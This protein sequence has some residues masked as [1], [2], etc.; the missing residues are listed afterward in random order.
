MKFGCL[1]AAL[2]FVV[3][4]LSFAL[5][6]AAPPAQYGNLTGTV[7]TQ[8]PAVSPS[9]PIQ[10]VRVRALKGGHV[11][12]TTVT[13]SQGGYSFTH[14]QTGNY[15]LRFRLASYFPVSINTQVQANTTRTEDAF[16]TPKLSM[17]YLNAGVTSTRNWR[18][19]NNHTFSVAYTWSI[20][21]SSMSGSGVATPGDSTFTTPD[22]SKSQKLQL[23]VNG[24]LTAQRKGFKPT[25][26]PANGFLAG[27]VTDS[28]ALPLAGVTVSVTNSTT[29]ALVADDL[30]ASDGSYS[31]E[32]SPGTYDVSFSLTGYSSFTAP[33]ITV[34]ANMTAAQNA[35]LNALPTS[36]TVTGTVTDFSGGSGLEGAFVEVLNAANNTIGSDTTD[37]DGT[38]SIDV[39]PGPC[40]VR[41]T[42]SGYSTLVTPGVS[43][44]AGNTTIVD[45]AL[46]AVPAP[47]TGHLMGFVTDDATSLPIGGATVQV[48]DSNN[49]QVGSATTDN[50]QGGFDFQ[51]NP[52]TYSINVT[53]PGYFSG[54]ASGLI[55]VAG[56]S[57]EADVSLVSI[58]PNGTVS[59]I[60][61][62]IHSVG[63]AGVSISVSNSNV[64]TTT[65]ANGT[66]SL[67]LPPGS[68]TLTFS[69]NAY[70]DLN[71][72]ATVVSSQTTTINVTL[73]VATGHVIGV[74]RDTSGNPLEDVAVQQQPSGAGTLTLADGSYDLEIPAGT[75]SLSYSKQWYDTQTISNIVVST[76]GSTTQNVNLVHSTGALDIHVT[77]SVTNN[78]LAGVTVTLQGLNQPPVI[79]TTSSPN[80]LLLQALPSGPYTVTFSKTG[81]AT[82][83][84]TTTV[85]VAATAII[86]EA[87]DPTTG[88]LS[89]SVFVAH[90]VTGANGHP[91]AAIAPLS[92]ATVQVLDGSSAVVAT[93]TT[94]GTGS[95]SA[96]GIFAG[97]YSVNVSSGALT[98]ASVSGVT[99][100]A[101]YNTVVQDITLSPP[102]PGVL[103]GVVYDP[104]GMPLSGV[105]ISIQG[106]DGSGTVTS[107]VD[108]SYVAWASAGTYTVTYS[109]TG[110]NTTSLANVV[111]T[112]GQVTTQPTTLTLIPTASVEVEVEDTTG[113]L[114]PFA[115]VE[116]DF[117]DG[118]TFVPAKQTDVNGIA[119]FT[120]VKLGGPVQI[121]VTTIEAT[122]QAA[123]IQ[124]DTGFAPGLN[125]ARLFV[126]EDTFPTG[127]FATTLDANGSPL[128][129]TVRVLDG[130][131]NFVTGSSS[132]EPPGGAQM[133]TVPPGTYSVQSSRYGY[134]TVT[135]TGVVV[136]HGRITFTSAKMLPDPTFDAIVHFSVTHGGNPA[137]GAT[138]SIDYGNGHIPAAQTD[139]N[140]LLTFT[141]QPEGIPPVITVMLSDGTTSVFTWLPFKSGEDPDND[142]D[143]AD[144]L[145]AGTVEGT[146]T[147]QADGTPIANALVV[148]VPQNG[149]PF[150]TTTDAAGH[151]VF[152][153]FWTNV[154]G[155]APNTITFSKSG[156]V[157]RT[158][159]NMPVPSGQVTADN[160][161]LA[162]DPF[163]GNPS[164]A[165]VTVSVQ[166]GGNPAP[167]ATVIIDY[168]QGHTVVG[169]TDAYSGIAVFTHQLVGV[170]ATISTTLNDQTFWGIFT[171]DPFKSGDSDPANFVTVYDQRMGGAV[172]GTVTSQADGTPL[173][174]VQVAASYGPG[175]TYG[176]AHTVTDSTGH[177]A[178]YTVP[179]NFTSS[180]PSSF[181]FSLN[182]YS[183][184]TISNV[185]LQG[186]EFKT[187]NVAMSPP[188]LAN[189]DVTVL[190]NVTNNGISNATVTLTYQSGS[191]A[192]TQTD[193]NGLA[194]FANQPAGVP[195]T[196]NVT[197]N[198]GSGRTASQSEPSGFTAGSNPV[199]IGINPIV[200]AVEGFVTDSATGAA[201]YAVD[202]LVKTASGATFGHTLSNPDGSYLAMN[203]PLGNYTLTFSH[204]GYA[205]QVLPLSITTTTFLVRNIVMAPPRTG[206]QG[207]V[208]DR[209]THLPLAG[210]LVYVDNN[211]H[212]AGQT[213][214]ASDG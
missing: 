11:V 19:R 3:S 110:Y 18:V 7:R 139:T 117:L 90:F 204:A 8:A 64:S 187:L 72:P 96:N 22:F 16:L 150:Q 41:F 108:G 211:G 36:G 68:Y 119:T 161:A 186:G 77:D 123:V 75:V 202:I 214:T 157:T 180:L 134:Q 1:R 84:D 42:L 53:A 179:T 165:T 184:T 151:Y 189:V 88:S 87:L 170:P 193:G 58:P 98:P 50:I 45:A 100:T 164:D 92:G 86:S 182:G 115:I 198:D 62:D 56:Q 43:V 21:G 97:T 14:L 85:P 203:L 95:Y 80:D 167:G 207:I 136:T 99:I 212:T 114:Q 23:F 199:Q 144:A 9:M 74:V 93:A 40:S 159:T 111:L 60:V 149:V 94:D 70:I 104:N 135:Q 44:T 38:Y 140:G 82:I 173:A 148:A 37:V 124:S 31:I 52:G 125:V 51:L 28:H 183:T 166:A 69:K 15:K 63:L 160:V 195:C 29:H 126:N 178:F 196:I 33:G 155:N 188:P 32:L 174:N 120:N 67:S 142:I 4:L 133:E 57:T 147:S 154:T 162:V 101:G 78:V 59:G 185:T 54:S 156:F 116:I 213:T 194:H 118:S 81:Y 103:E 76:N 25:P 209:S 12:A 122:P 102:A 112:P 34:M 169:Q 168:G 71:S 17:R 20:T 146:V 55:V 206:V 145:Y 137:V 113:I 172:L 141:N 106:A 176:T 46:H 13:N 79:A 128:P 47:T 129:A 5:A 175:G 73:K 191:P 121:N 27:S 152:Y 48:L 107:G 66:Y 105:S 132:A 61:T 197:V 158:L 208:T 2:F 109:K 163:W 190:D 91:V 171:T 210:A 181:T 89:G 30:T 127:I 143:I 130:N 192:T 24:I 10:G 177:Y 49:N 65:A 201:I 153:R 138:I 131:G 26:P 35:A 39:P 83:V 6:F 200:G 205:T